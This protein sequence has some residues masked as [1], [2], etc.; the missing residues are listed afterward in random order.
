MLSATMT[1]LLSL[2]PLCC[3]ANHRRLVERCWSSSRRTKAL[4]VVAVLNVV[5]LF[6][7][8]YV[9]H[10]GHG[11]AANRLDPPSSSS[12]EGVRGGR[13]VRRDGRRDV[14]PAKLG[15]CIEELDAVVIEKD[16]SA[17][18][19]AGY[20]GRCSGAGT[21]GGN[22]TSD[23]LLR[24]P[25]TDLVESHRWQPVHE[26]ERETFVFSAF[27]DAR[28]RPPAVRIIGLSS[29]V[30]PASSTWSLNGG[31][32]SGGGVVKYCRLWYVGETE[33]EVVQ[34]EYNI[35]P[36]THERR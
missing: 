32:P 31:G 8:V 33:P 2:Q 35:V 21:G 3:C 29:G 12:S 19:A 16:V 4:V 7:L 5:F 13:G 34:A 18:A 24:P 17:T 10:V 22:W 23:D 1:I 30:Y 27:F 6:S 25:P 11:G 28:T 15:L 9:A 14:K 26:G 36:E 20:R